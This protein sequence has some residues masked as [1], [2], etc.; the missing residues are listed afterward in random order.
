[1]ELPFFIQRLESSAE[2]LRTLVADLDPD[3]AR[4]SRLLVMPPQFSDPAGMQPL[5]P[6]VSAEQP[7]LLQRGYNALFGDG[8][9]PQ[10]NPPGVGTATPRAPGPRG[11]RGPGGRGPARRTASP[12]MSITEIDD[13]IK[14]RGDSL[15]P[16]ELKAIQARLVALGAR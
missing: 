13:L 8:S 11:P 15:S 3:Q 7:G 10:P 5:P 6:G 16:T 4:W 2:T 14:G 12:Q 9:T 1:M